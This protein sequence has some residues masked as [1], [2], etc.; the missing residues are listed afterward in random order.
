[1]SEFSVAAERQ[2]VK[3]LGKSELAGAPEDS[4]SGVT[5]REESKDDWL[6]GALRKMVGVE[7]VRG[8]AGYKVKSEP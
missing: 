3:L 1:M 5:G 7:A 8:W 2:P 6:G 4:G